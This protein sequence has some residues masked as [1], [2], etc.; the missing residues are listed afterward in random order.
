MISAKSLDLNEAGYDLLEAA[1]RPNVSSHLSL[2]QHRITELQDYRIF[3]STHESDLIHLYSSKFIENDEQIVRC[4]AFDHTMF[5]SI[6][7]YCSQKFPVDF[8]K[9]NLLE[10]YKFEVHGIFPGH[11]P[12]V[13]GR[14]GYV[15][16]K[17]IPFNHNQRDK[18]FNHVRPKFFDCLN[19]Q[20]QRVFVV[21]VNSGRDYVFHYASM[22]KHVVGMFSVQTADKIEVIRYPQAEASIHIWTDLNTSIVKKEDLVILGYVE[23]IDR[24]F[25]SNSRLEY[26]DTVD[27]DYYTSIRYIN[28]NSNTSVNLIGVKFSFWGCISAKII[29]QICR[30]G[31]QEVI[32]VGKLGTLASPTDIYSR[33]FMPSRFLIMYHDKIVCR[34]QDLKNNLLAFYPDMS[35]NYHVSVPTVVEEDYVQRKIT[36][37]LKIDSIDNEVSQMAYAVAQFN[38]EFTKDVSFSAIHFATDYIRRPTERNLSVEFD[39]SNNRTKEA[40]ERKIDILDNIAGKLTEYLEQR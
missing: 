23:E 4:G 3:G 20:G 6:D 7:Q 19:E 12:K 30:L 8:I 9:Q 37:D 17:A 35:T 16:A 34:I 21:A 5:E 29:A 24:R 39:L 28:K 13:A 22:L 26:V 32:Y 33:V 11:F 1:N 40:F 38:R 2:L 31:A 36:A 18:K 10:G 14:L 25:R 27:T 15:S